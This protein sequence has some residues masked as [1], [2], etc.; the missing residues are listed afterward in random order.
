[1][2]PYRVQFVFNSQEPKLMI[3]IVENIVKVTR[4]LT[5]CDI[6]NVGASC[7]QTTNLNMNMQKCTITFKEAYFSLYIKEGTLMLL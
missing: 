4:G 7:G 6:H 1:M 2:F 5:K 3:Q